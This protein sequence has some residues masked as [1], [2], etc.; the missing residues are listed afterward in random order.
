MA[1]NRV[2]TARR[3]A[4]FACGFP[5]DGLPRRALDAARRCLIDLFGSAAVGFSVPSA[6]IL[7]ETARAVFS[8]GEA[9]VWFSG[10]RLQAPASA[11]ANSGAASALDLDD[12]HRAAGGHPGASI[13]PAA[14]AV[15]EETGAS[16]LEFLATVVCGYEVAVRVAA[17]RDFSRLDT[18]ST[19]RWCA[20]G[21]AAAAGRLRKVPPEILAEALAVSG[22]QSPGLSA[23]GYSAVMG[24]HVKEG[25]PWA[26]A[27]GLMALELARRGFTGPVDILD[28]PDYY[29]ASKITSQLGE[30]FAVERV[31]FKPYACCRWIHS[32]LDALLDLMEAEGL[33]ASDIR[34]VR[35]KTFGRALRLNNYPDPATLEGAQYSLPFCLAVAAF[36]GREALL[37]MD[38]GALGNRE[39]IAWAERVELETDPA[40][41]VLFPERT[42]ARVRL[43]TRGGAYE[44]QVE[45]PLGDP[46]HP[47][48]ESLL[49]EK[50][51]RLSRGVLNPGA[52]K[53]V[54]DAVNG[55]DSH[56]SLNG[57][58]NGL[59]GIGPPAE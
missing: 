35:V 50:F 27:T 39:V 5:T 7:R 45:H 24:N 36:G 59:A 57:I 38:A 22:V 40:L 52:Q 51:R 48:P 28:H 23:S 6:K 26:T 12:G 58:L 2:T 21:A 32:A 18:L 49:H 13:I 47:M 4:D 43:E 55:L 15:A 34:R 44:K 29:D 11:L 9:S 16:G 10:D 54:L 20:Y 33:V 1:G 56:R 31:Y 8:K 42:P 37:P 30:T 19:G 41:D 25:I 46:L 17:A 53:R 14:L 3:L